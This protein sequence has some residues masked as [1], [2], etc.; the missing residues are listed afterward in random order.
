MD[1]ADKLQ[2]EQPPEWVRR[3]D[4]WA[5]GQLTLDGKPIC[6]DEWVEVPAA[7][8]TR[9]DA[10]LAQLLADRLTEI[11]QTE[12]EAVSALV[13]HRVRC[14]PALAGHPTVQI[15]GDQ[16]GGWVGLV[17]ILNGLCGSTLPGGWP[18]I[19]AELTQDDDGSVHCI[20]FTANK[21]PR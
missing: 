16:S 2:P 20:G 19:V 4:A 18:R 13:A 10:A 5:D 15:D 8:S 7:R 12:P 3:C 9:V 17:G 21:P 11:C 6:E 14:G 1:D